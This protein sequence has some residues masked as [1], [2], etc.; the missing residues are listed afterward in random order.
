MASRRAIELRASLIRELEA[1]AQREASSQL[2]QLQWLRGELENYLDRWL[3]FAAVDGISYSSLLQGDLFIMVLVAA[4][5]YEQ[6]LCGSS[7]KRGEA[8]WH[9]FRTAL[10]CAQ[11]AKDRACLIGLR[12]SLVAVGSALNL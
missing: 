5:V 11:S 6:Q 10:T 8:E 1:V 4:E 12:E 9:Q 7:S 2:D 3:G